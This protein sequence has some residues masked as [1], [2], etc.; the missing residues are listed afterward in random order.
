MG[1]IMVTMEREKLRPKL[2]LSQDTVI[3][4]MVMDMDT[5]MDITAMV[6]MVTMEREKLRLKLS[7][8]TAIMV[9]D[10]V[11]VM[12]MDIDM[13]TM[14]NCKANFLCRELSMDELGQ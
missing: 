6:I 11:M 8:D 1:D 14:D 5:V 12:D 13:D 3:M 9:M 4:V 7:Q 10:M 2:L